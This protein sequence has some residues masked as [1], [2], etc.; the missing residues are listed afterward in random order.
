MKPARS[1][2]HWADEIEL[3]VTDEGDD[4]HA[5]DGVVPGGDRNP[6]L[7]ERPGRPIGL[8]WCLA[9][10]SL[11]TAGVLAG[12]L[13]YADRTRTIDRTE[14]TSTLG[15]AT[16]NL[17]GCPVQ[18]TCN[19]GE[20]PDGGD[21]FGPTERYLPGAALVHADWVF[22][23]GSAQD[24]RVSLVVRTP[25]GMLVTV[26]ATRNLFGP[27][28]PAWQSPIPAVG[29]ADIALVVPGPRPGTALAVTATVPA[30]V[31]VPAVGLQSLAAD[32][33]LQLS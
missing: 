26:T 27:A 1:N 20:L 30:G 4:A 15:R 3:V 12:G 11:A 2:R 25:S 29:P 17:T 22:D 10:V 23:S 21:L 5:P 16:E 13:L 8:R 14:V 33:S 24:Y 32:Q 28:V 31:A 19:F 7:P 6:D 18:A 9:A